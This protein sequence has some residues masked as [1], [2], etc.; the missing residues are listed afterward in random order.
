MDA[1]GTRCDAR[2]RMGPAGA[3]EA[4]PTATRTSG[5]SKADIMMPTACACGLRESHRLGKE[6][7]NGR[8]VC[9]I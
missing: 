3:A 9:Q 4:G 5:R 7:H 8:V 2:A 6:T 1:G